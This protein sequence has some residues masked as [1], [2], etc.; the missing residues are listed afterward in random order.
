MS[1]LLVRVY[2]RHD[3]SQKP[4]PWNLKKNFF[5]DFTLEYIIRSLG[6]IWRACGSTHFSDSEKCTAV[7]VM[8]WCVIVCPDRYDWSG[9]Q[10]SRAPQEDADQG[11]GCQSHQGKEVM[12]QVVDAVESLQHLNFEL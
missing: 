8:V 1:Y 9:N 3:S 6:D 7:E 5:C 11:K 12:Y 2:E 10:R 4:D